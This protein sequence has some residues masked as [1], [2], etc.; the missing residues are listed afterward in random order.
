MTTIS[1]TGI[2]S[3]LDVTSILSKLMEV[4]R[5]PLAQIQADGAKIQSKLSVYGKVQSYVSALG[6]AAKTL[7][8]KTAWGRTTA[9]SG[10]EKVFTATTS[11]GAT[12]GSY[13]VQ[14]NALAAGQTLAST[15]FTSKTEV[16][17]AGTLSIE[18]GQ[19]SADQSS[20]TAKTGVTKVDVTI[21]ATD[22]LENVRTKIN[23]ANAGVTASIVTDATGSK[24]VMRSTTTGAENAFRVSVADGD[25]V[26]DS[27][28][29]SRLAYDPANGISEMSRT[30]AASNA[31][32]VIDGITISSATNKVEGAIEGV[33]FQLVGKSTGTVDLTLSNDSAAMQTDVQAFVKAYNDL[34]TYLTNQTKY[35]SATKT[36][37]TL[38]GD[39]G[40]NALRAALRSL[41][42]ATSGASSVFDRLAEVGLDPQSDGTLKINSSKLTTALASP[43]EL[44]KMFS[45]NG[46]GT[47]DDGFAQKIKTW[48][49]TLLGFDGAITSRTNSLQ[50][51]ITANTKKQTAFED[52]MTTVEAR[53]KAQYSTLD[54]K[55]GSLTALSTYVTQQIANWNK[56]SA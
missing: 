48:S 8:D 20:F 26:Q 11:T 2:G 56:S 22:T 24:L 35:D 36:A 29:L 43:A 41:G 3:G 34:A 47:S 7:A 25:G 54:T 15:S 19:W 10:D 52:R 51:Q 31:E 21:S 16:V 39:S 5:A 6:D 44:Q 18:L 12:A 30:Q 33:T 9:V 55:M 50:S 4:E 53:L 46:T 40:A 38:Q 13:A 17:G 28:G 49:E 1:S 27:A 32:A 42:S 37:G 45:L 23:E 14:V